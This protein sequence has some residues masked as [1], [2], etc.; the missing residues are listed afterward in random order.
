MYL[1]RWIKELTSVVK[2][3]DGHLRRESIY[4][5]KARQFSVNA[6]TAKSKEIKG[7]EW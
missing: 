4:T 5:G 1:N 2:P 7:P 3:L 6:L